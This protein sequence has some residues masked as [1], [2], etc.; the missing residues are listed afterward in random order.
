[1]N[2]NFWAVSV[3]AFYK[4]LILIENVTTVGCVTRVLKVSAI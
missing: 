2:E 3:Y 1:M 4:L